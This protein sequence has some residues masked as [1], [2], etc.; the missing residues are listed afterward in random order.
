MSVRPTFSVM[1]MT[2][3]HAQHAVG[4]QCTVAVTPIV[5]LNPF[6]PDGAGCHAL[7]KEDASCL[8]GENL[9]SPGAWGLLPAPSLTL[10]VLKLFWGPV[11]PSEKWGS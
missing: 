3:S 5:N 8:N 9:G 10:Q 6:T 7:Q 1:A 11:F 2:G 4:V